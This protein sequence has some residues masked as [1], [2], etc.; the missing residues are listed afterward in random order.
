MRAVFV[1]PIVLLPAVAAAEDPSARSDASQSVETGSFLPFTDAPSNEVSYAKT[2]GSYDGARGSPALDTTVEGK[3]SEKLQI[4]G[5]LLLQAGEV[6]PSIE[7][8]LDV[9]SKDKDGFDLQ[10]AAGFD[11]NGFNEVPAVF[12]RISGGADYRGTYLIAA[13][14]FALGTQEGER[15]AGLGLAGI[16]DLGGHVYLGFDSQL[17]VDAERD[18]M[19]PDGEATWDLQ[20]GPLASYARGHFAATAAMGLTARQERTASTSDAGAYG[21]IG[22][23]AV[24]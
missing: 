24:F 19:E 6:D 9:L 13:T 1:L 3:L 14:T 22:V 7:G 2:F 15:A 12:A 11:A 17:R 8:Q 10:L 16:R 18:R 5:R 23:G 20:S 21:T 4:E